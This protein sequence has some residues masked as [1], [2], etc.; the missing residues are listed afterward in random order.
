MPIVGEIKQGYE[1]GQRHSGKFIWVPCALC[2]KERWVILHKGLPRSKTCKSCTFKL[3]EQRERRRILSTGRKHT[4]STKKKL[5][6]AA[7]G[8]FCEANSHWS[9]GRYK[10]RG[11][12]FVKLPPNDFFYSMAKHDGYVL[13]HRLVVAR[14]LGRCLHL[15]EVVHHKNHIRD[16]NRIDNLQLVS[17]D[18]HNQITILENYI[19]TLEKRVYELEHN[20]SLREG[21]ASMG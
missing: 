9:G 5:K 18:R 1:I 4:E 2:G 19:K 20:G 14:G 13:E 6:V 16:D 15:W 17:D 8:R 10:E 7:T 12:V 11:Y 21:G 3:P